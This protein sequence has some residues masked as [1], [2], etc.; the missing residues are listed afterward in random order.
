MYVV[1]THQSYTD[2]IYLT[3]IAVKMFWLDL[4]KYH[5][6]VTFSNINSYNLF[7]SH[8]LLYAWYMNIHPCMYNQFSYTYPHE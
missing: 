7:K 1:V 5:T 4:R 6:D 8:C 2:R 3:A